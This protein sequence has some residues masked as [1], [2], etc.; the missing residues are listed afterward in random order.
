MAWYKVTDAELTAIAD[1]IREYEG[2][3]GPIS[4][5]KGFVSAIQSI[6]NI[7][8]SVTVEQLLSHT[9]SG[10]VGNRSISAIRP[11]AFYSCSALEKVVFPNCETIG[12]WA[13][14]GC[15]ML[16]TVSIPK[17]IE[18]GSSAFRQCSALSV[19]SFPECQRMGTYAFESCVNLISAY[20]MGSAVV[21]L[22]GSPF[23][24]TPIGGYSSSAGQFGSIY[25]P[26]SL[27]SQYQ[28][29]PYWSYYSSRMVGVE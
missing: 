1:R 13:F 3:S 17:C 20:F 9:V 29:A 25:V 8:N 6:N 2:A 21:Q 16:T 10:Y 24:S 7:F 11:Y 28:S 22:S 23:A 4:Y 15:G 26:A 27:L 14:Y 18:I 5:P 12:S 19:I